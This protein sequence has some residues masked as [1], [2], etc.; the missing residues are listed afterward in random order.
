MKIKETNLN[1]TGMIRA[2]FRLTRRCNN[3]CPHCYV[4]L[5]LNSKVKELS[6]KNWCDII[7]QLTINNINYLSFTGGEPTLYEGF[8]EVYLYAKKKGM[9]V[10]LMTNATCFDETTK[11]LLYKYP[12][13]EI[14]VT[15]YGADEE[16]YSKVTGNSNGWQD[17]LKNMDFLVKLQ[18]EKGTNFLLTSLFTKNT[19]NSIEGIDTFS[20]KYTD[21]KPDYIKVLYGRI[22]KN[23][24]RNEMIKARRPS[25]QELKLAIINLGEERNPCFNVPLSPQEEGQEALFLCSL[26]RKE[27][28]YFFEDGT[29]THC[30]IMPEGEYVLK[31]TEEELNNFDYKKMKE[32]LSKITEP[33]LNLKI[34]KKCATCDIRALCLSCPIRNLLTGIAISAYN[35]EICLLE[36]N[37]KPF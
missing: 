30:I 31:L 26:R 18:K 10:Q 17:F 25:M 36:L 23:F 32:K 16:T 9:V 2:S 29:M 13:Y 8:K 34:N 14:S 3:N 27:S 5:P 35:K 21:K 7:D 11:A 19:I 37:P 4:N 28:I 15:I 33:L 24:E 22:D 20:L 12:P 6:V 1:V